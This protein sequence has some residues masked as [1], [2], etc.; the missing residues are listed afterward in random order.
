[1]VNEVEEEDGR[2]DGAEV[3]D[4]EPIET[5]PFLDVWLMPCILGRQRPWGFET[6]VGQCSDGIWLVR[7]GNGGCF[8][9]D[10]PTHWMPLPES[11]AR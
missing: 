4:W 3:S 8:E 5:A 9:T 7:D 1:M 6:W 11:P 10:R 2:N